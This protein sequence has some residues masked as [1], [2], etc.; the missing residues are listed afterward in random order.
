MKTKTIKAVCLLLALCLLAGAIAGC[1]AEE[2][3]DLSVTGRAI[4]HELEFGGVYI[5]LSID[6]FNAL[7]FSY[8]DGVTVTFSNGYKL[9]NVPYYNGYYTQT[10]EPL[11][12]A[13]PGYPY[14]KACI[15]NGDDLWTV[16]GLGEGDTADISLAEAGAFAAIQNAR[17][18]HYKDDRELFASDEVFANFRSVKA[19][20]IGENKLFRSA[21]PCDNQHSRAPYVDALIK[22]AGVGCVLNLSDNDEK[23]AGYLAKEDYNSPY[24]RSLYE[25]GGVIPLALNMNF[26]SADFRKKVADG[27]IEMIGH[28]GPYLVHC[29]EGKDRT[30]FVCMLLE[31]L[32]GAGYDEI[33]EDYMI[34]YDNYYGITKDRDEA[35]YTVILENVLDPMIRSVL[36]DEKADLRTADLAG[37][38][39]TLLKNAGMTDAQIATLREKLGA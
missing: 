4:T 34:T 25:N 24:F 27:L 10:G 14:I 38:A 3:K 5:D 30:G 21:S 23:I 11:L 12:V 31:A 32:C 26:G 29:T 37:A 1:G 15:N 35:R 17:D 8:G 16:A 28:E 36:G 19:T 2:E 22:A 6:D 20:G 18:I 13:Y 7:G 39:E 9:E 33:A